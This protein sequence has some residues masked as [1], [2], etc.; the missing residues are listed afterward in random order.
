[1]LKQAIHDTIAKSLNKIGAHET[2]LILDHP[3]DLQFGDYTTN[4]A[5]QLAKP[6]K[7]SPRVIAQEIIDNIEPSPYIYKIEIA[8][9]GFI[10]IWVSPTLQYGEL[11]TILTSS[12]Y[13]KLEKTNRKT[14]IE[15][16]DPNPFKEFHVGHLYQ[17]AIGESLARLHEATGDDVT[18]LCYQGDVGLHVAK[19]IW[20]MHKLLADRGQELHYYEHKPIEERAAFMGEAYATGAKIF[21]E[22]EGVAAEIRQLNKK[23]YEKDSSVVEYYDTGRRWSLE[24]FDTI[25][26]KLN[27]KFDG[28]IFESEV[29]PKGIEIVRKYLSKGVF[30]ESD[31][32]V[33]FPGEDYGLH[34]RVFIN[35]L[36]LPTYEAKDIGLAHIKQEQY[37]PDLSIIITGNEVNEYFKVILKVLEIVNP[38]LRKKTVHLSHG[39]VR[40][41]EG[42]MSS[43]TGKVITAN[44]LLEQASESA[45]DIIQQS[46]K[47]LG[48]TPES[49]SITAQKIA[50]AAV[51]YALL[52][53]GIG[54]DVEFSFKESI[55]FEGNSGAYLLYTYVRCNSILNKNRNTIA[56][57]EQIPLERLSINEQK[58][59]RL[60]TRFTDIV[61]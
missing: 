1:M 5:M 18:R 27:T 37:N 25:Y 26:H 38:E 16:I 23:I 28:H 49:L 33:V 19:S 15:Y 40:L 61:Q 12:Y 57:I 35:S 60:L 3:E 51:K 29:G 56:N 39:M 8:G 6:L 47:K 52:K 58:I 48:H 54:K 7:K 55:N 10:N 2:D 30:K 24:Y 32:A 9:P 41:P 31:G 34:T 14:T 20:G 42:K 44:A 11:N 59:L 46:N 21:T 36:G 17:G 50:L 45:I 4:I 22:D 53:N 13:G 43:R